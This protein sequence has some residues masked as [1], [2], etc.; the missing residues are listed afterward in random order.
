MHWFALRPIESAPWLR[1]SVWDR[2]LDVILIFHSQKYCRIYWTIMQVLSSGNTPGNRAND[3]F[4]GCICLRESSGGMPRNRSSVPCSLFVFC[5]RVLCHLWDACFSIATL[6]Y[7]LGV[8]PPSNTL[9][10]ALM[11]IYCRFV[12]GDAH[13]P[14]CIGTLLVI[15]CALL[16]YC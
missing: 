12:V 7:F 1:E 5:R 2:T 11:C 13:S 14:A 8:S 9:W 4:P 15:V 16:T 10:L 6:E 3:S